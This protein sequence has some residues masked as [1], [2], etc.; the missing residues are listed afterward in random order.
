MSLSAI[1]NREDNTMA[2]SQ[3]PS[4]PAIAAVST[5]A[6]GSALAA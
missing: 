3:Y 2:E 6:A 1:L 4:L 5:R